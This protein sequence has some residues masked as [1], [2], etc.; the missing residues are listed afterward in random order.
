MSN[1][2][3]SMNKGLTVKD[4]VTTGIFTALLFVF[5]LVGGVFFATN[6]VLTFFMPAGGGLLAGP[7]YLLLIAKVHKRWSLS[8]M[9]VIMGII[10]FVTGMHWAFALGYMIMAIVALLAQDSTKAKN[11]TACLI[12]CSL[13]VAL[14]HIS[15][16][17]LTPTAGR[18]PCWET[19]LNRVTSTPCRQL[20]I[21][22]S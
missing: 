10:W 11:S 21:P 20:Q 14:V 18:R 16:S 13:S 7:I 1:Q 9:G 4:L 12:S 3:N 5:V 8:I 17:L 22:A 2:V 6:P 19:E 15:C